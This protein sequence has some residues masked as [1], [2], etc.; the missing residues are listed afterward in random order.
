M[1]NNDIVEKV[2]TDILAQLEAGVVPW[3]QPWVG[4][5]AVNVISGKAYRGINV[6]ILWAA[7]RKRGLDQGG[8][9]TFKQAQSVGGCVRKG[10]KG[11]AVV[12][13]KLL[14]DREDVNRTIPLLRHYTV[15]HTSQCDG[16]PDGLTAT[17]GTDGTIT[18]AEALV[19]LYADRPFVETGS[20]AYYTPARDIV[21]LPSKNRFESLAA[22]YHTLYHE[23][24]HSTGHVSRLKRAEVISQERFGSH[25]YGVEELTA[26]M[27]AA[28]ACARV[29]LG[30]ETIQP[31][32]SYLKS[33]LGVLKAE[34]KML[35]TAAARAQKAFDYMTGMTA[36][37][38][39]ETMA[40]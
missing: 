37:T 12:M 25:A 11:T 28:F 15:F 29:G 31:S 3:R 19:E 21:T 9:L 7:A 22:Y 23:F 40:E 20:A 1:A 4:G 35:I 5:G 32:A 24:A 33:W 27:T 26:E 16:L 2:T 39:E 18:E 17:P 8:W 38:H 10:E 34:P 13:W 36:V 14:Q 30:A 6:W